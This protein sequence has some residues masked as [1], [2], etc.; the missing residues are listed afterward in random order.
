[1][2]DAATITPLHPT[3][4]DTAAAHERSHTPS[5][6]RPV[7]C[8]LATKPK[9][10][11]TAHAEL[12][13]RGFNAYLPLVTTQRRDR[14]WHTGPLWPGYLFVHI[15]LDQPWNPVRYCP[16]VFSL[17]SVNGTPSVCPD[18]QMAAVQG[19]VHA[20][21]TAGRGE[22]ADNMQFPPGTL[23]AVANGVLRNCHGIV[24]ARHHDRADVA[25]VM[26]GQ[27]RN[28]SIRLS[29]LRPRS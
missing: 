5:G 25:L 6:S 15:R 4:R 17:L 21:E 3:N 27:L 20:A 9:A 24:T 23:V 2:L 14:S 28:L 12:H 19:A 11:R 8:V 1:M 22:G 29:D 13:R 18:S 7:W 10:E 16:G 26:F